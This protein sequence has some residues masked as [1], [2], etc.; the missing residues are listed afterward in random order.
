MH[1]GEGVTITVA[2]Y[3]F[4]RIFGSRQYFRRFFPDDV[5]KEL[6]VVVGSF[7]PTLRKM[8]KDQLDAFVHRQVRDPANLTFLM[9]LPEYLKYVFAVMPDRKNVVVQ[10]EDLAEVLQN[11]EMDIARVLRTASP[12]SFPTY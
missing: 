8:S 11:M 6:E 4:A 3:I 12:H 10:R 7:T 1:W 9:T 5:S 2:M